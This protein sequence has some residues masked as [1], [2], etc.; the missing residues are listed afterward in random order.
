MRTWA[1]AEAKARLSEVIEQAI[2]EGPQSITR[3]GC[4][5]AV[6]VAAEQRQRRT[7]RVGS[8]VEFFV[9]FPL[10]GSVRLNGVL[11]PATRLEL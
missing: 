3:R 6:V 5:A 8:L 4:P 10:R 7:K 9:A 1:L 2:S 11:I